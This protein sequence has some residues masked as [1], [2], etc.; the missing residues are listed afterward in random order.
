MLSSDTLQFGYKVGTSTTQC[1]WLVT[2]VV[3]YFLQRGSNPIITLLDCSKA[4]NTS[5]FSILFSKLIKRGVPPI[6]ARTLI[7]VYEDQ[8]AWVK[9]GGARSSTFPIINGTRQGSILSPA[10]FAVYVDD[11]L[12]ELRTLGVGCHVAGVFYGAVGFCDDILLLSP[13]RDAMEMMLATCERFAARNNLQFSTDPNPSK[14]KT[15]CIFVFGKRKKLAKPAPLTL[16]GKELPWVAS[17]THLGHELHETGTMDHW[18][19]TLV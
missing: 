18:T 3:N 11:L 5:K 4:F 12:Q 8:Y 16:Y 15:K 1:S 7:V 10:L 6:V 9:W 19:M 14:S 13:T 17:A 2:E